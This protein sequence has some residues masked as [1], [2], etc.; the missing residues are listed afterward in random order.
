MNYWGYEVQV[1][2]Y[3]GSNVLEKQTETTEKFNTAGLETDAKRLQVRSVY[4]CVQPPPDL[5]CNQDIGAQRLSLG[6]T[7]LAKFFS[8]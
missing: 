4:C 5:Q 2:N 3:E 6:K 8:I 1:G 7:N